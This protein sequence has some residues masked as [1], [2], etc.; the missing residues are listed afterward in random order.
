MHEWS[1]AE[2]VLE[3][4]SELF[5]DRLILEVNLR[6]GEL[7]GLEIEALAEALKILSRG[8]R[9]ENAKFNLSISKA[10]F[11]CLSCGEEW[12]VNK[13]LEIVKGMLHESG[14]VVEEGGELESPIH[15]IPG[16]IAGL[17]RCPRC[18]RMDIDVKSGN[19]IEILSVVVE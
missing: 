12:D 13:A 1:I 16:L 14:Y 8:T 17:Q 2:G 19:E 9:L 5:K 10:I 15:F 18:G 11:K 4:L 6:I 3:A 7:R